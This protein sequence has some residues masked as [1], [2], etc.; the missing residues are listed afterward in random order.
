MVNFDND[1]EQCLKVLRGGGLILYP[2]D[3]VWGIGCDATNEQAAQRIYRLKNRQD[4]NALIV[5]VAEERDVLQHIANPDYRIF[6]YLR[7][8]TKPTTVIYR[9]A[10]G[11]SENIIG[12]DGSIAIRICQDEFCR[13]LLKRFRKPIVSTSANISGKPAPSTFADI[14]TEVKIGVD[15][16]VTYRQDDTVPANPSFLVKWNKDGT[17]TVLRE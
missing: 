12:K 4:N 9:N 13:H 10:I 5:L 15:Y 11:L 2:T 3:T 17:A 16:V 8:T 14:Q 1:I 6:E 7:E